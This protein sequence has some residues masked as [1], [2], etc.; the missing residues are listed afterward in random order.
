LN[1]ALTEAQISA[2][3]D[4]GFLHYRDFLGPTEVQQL[5]A[6]ALAAAA[7]MGR[8]KVTG[9]AAE[10]VEGDTYYDRVFTQRINLW[11]ICDTVKACMLDPSLGRM[12]CALEGID[13]IRLWHDQLFIKEPLA[14]PTNLHLDDPYWSFYSRH[15]ITVW[16]ALEDATL[17]NGCLCFCPGSHKRASYENISIGKEHDF[18]AIAR[19]YPGV[20]ERAPVPVPMQAGDCS[21]HNGL[22]VHGAGVNLTLGRRIAMTA[23]YMPVGSTFNG[24]QNILPDAYLRTLKV[25]DEL[26]DEYFNPLVWA[27][28]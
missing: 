3:R 28:G 27:A 13:G 11:R 15:A 8:R 25:G 5:R 14:N 7:T 24:Q 20:L 17:E 12:L 1:T 4:D 19:I 18:G 23:A 22:T 21:F 26:D 16:I 6:A 2:Y 10:L 9:N